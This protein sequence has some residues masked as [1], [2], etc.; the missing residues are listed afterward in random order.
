MSDLVIVLLLIVPIIIVVFI[1][2][3]AGRKR[4]KKIQKRINA[5]ITEATKQ[6]GI[7]NYYRKQLI[8][9]TVIIDENARKLLLVDH[10]GLYTYDVYSLDAIKGNQVVNHRNSFV[11]EG[12]RQKQEHVTT[13]IGIEL[14]FK[15]IDGGKFITFY[16]HLEHNVYLLADFEKEAHQLREKIDNARTA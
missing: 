5:F 3:N 13:R 1:L 7:T 9:Q 8:Y 11:T 12:K 10:K 14:S 6:T 15:M 16:D 2:N 4:K